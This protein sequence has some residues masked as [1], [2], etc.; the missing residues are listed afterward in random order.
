MYA[1]VVRFEGASAGAPDALA[2]EINSADGPPEGVKA[3][4]IRMLADRSSGTMYVVTYFD[5]E[6]DMQAADAVFNEM[7]P[8][9]DSGAGTRAG[10]DMCEVLVDREA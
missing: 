8:P 6:E 3:N 2:Q 7:S 9:P 5:S 10:V 4:R 1:R